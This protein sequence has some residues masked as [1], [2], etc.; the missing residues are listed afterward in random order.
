MKILLVALVIVTVPF[1]CMARL[2]DDAKDQAISALCDVPA[3][4]G[5]NTCQEVSIVRV[6]SSSSQGDRDQPGET[7]H[8]CIEMKYKDFT[9]ESGSAVVWIAGPLQNG[10]FQVEQGPFFEEHCNN[11]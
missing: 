8:W 11:W 7:R 4:P 10:D 3:F 5:E 9:G 6:L 2:P 1:A